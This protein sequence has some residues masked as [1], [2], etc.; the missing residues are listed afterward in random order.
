MLAV[1]TTA[2]AATLLVLPVTSFFKLSK[3]V[4]MMGLFG[5]VCGFVIYSE[6]CYGT[7]FVFPSRQLVD[8]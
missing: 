7:F 1:T 3:T 6:P 2:R 5:G 4:L 8:G